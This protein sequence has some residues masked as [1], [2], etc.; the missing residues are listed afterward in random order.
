[1]QGEKEIKAMPIPAS[2][3]DGSVYR[4]PGLTAG[5]L[6]AALVP[7]ID[8][9]HWTWINLQIGASVYN[10]VLTFYGSCDPAALSSYSDPSWIPV[11]MYKTD[12]LNGADSFY[13]TDSTSSIFVGRPITFSYF[14]VIMNGYTSGSAEATLELRKDGMPGFSLLSISAA[15]NDGLQSRIGLTNNDG[16]QSISVA[17]GVTSDTV[18]CPNFGFL[19][20]VLVV[21]AGSNQMQFYDNASAGTGKIIGMI[22]ANEP[23]CSIVL[24]KA[25][26]ANGITI[27]GNMNNPAVTVF[28]VS[29]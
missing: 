26:C 2:I 9:S 21:N 22:P 15:L 6:N 8:V 13:Q 1:L 4:V 19:S 25:P 29:L 10:G 18:I 7:A 28:Y 11:T 16:I 20:S 24:P 3:D 5:A 27:E 17:A 12:R 23:A 14:Q